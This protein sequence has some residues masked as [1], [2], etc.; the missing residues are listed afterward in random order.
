MYMCICVRGWA[1]EEERDREAENRREG[2]REEERER[3]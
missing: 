2:G 1:S 3:M